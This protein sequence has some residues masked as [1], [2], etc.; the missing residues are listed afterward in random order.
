MYEMNM[1]EYEMNMY[2]YKMNM[3][4]YKMNMPG[5]NTDQMIMFGTV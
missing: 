2:E 3:Y 5:A 1:Y 4:E